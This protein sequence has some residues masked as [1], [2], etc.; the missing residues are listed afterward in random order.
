MNLIPTQSPGSSTPTDEPQGCTPRVCK[1]PLSISRLPF[2]WPQIATYSPTHHTH[3]LP[4]ALPTTHRPEIAVHYTQLTWAEANDGNYRDVTVQVC[5][6]FEDEAQP[7]S[8]KRCLS[9][10]LTDPAATA[11][12]S[13]VTGAV[14][15]RGCW[16]VPVAEPCSRV[17][18]TSASSTLN[19]FRRF[20]HVVYGAHRRHLRGRPRVRVLQERQAQ[21]QRPRRPGQET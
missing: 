8:T 15:R 18:C 11:P 7:L 5:A 4:H 3:H 13:F 21:P 12:H 16:F 10:H 17:R 6:H 2:A 14:H 9:L 20:R 19:R 1:Y